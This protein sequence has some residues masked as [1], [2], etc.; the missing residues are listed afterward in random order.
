MEETILGLLVVISG[1]LANLRFR[2][3][4]LTKRVDHLERLSSATMKHCGVE[5]SHMPV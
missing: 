3:K 5:P 1:Q 4:D 2:H